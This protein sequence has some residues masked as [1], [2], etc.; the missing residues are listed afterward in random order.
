MIQAK[1]AFKFGMLCG[2]AKESLGK[3]VGA[4]QA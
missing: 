4:A 1:K 2:D 3:P